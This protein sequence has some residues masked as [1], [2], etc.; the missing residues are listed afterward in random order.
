MKGEM[1]DRRR[2][3]CS[4]RSQERRRDDISGLTD[5][6]LELSRRNFIAM[7]GTIAA[8]GA[9]GSLLDPVSASASVRWPRGELGRQDA[10]RVRRSQ[11]MPVGRF[12]RWHEQ[13]ERVG[14]RNQRGLRAAGS[15]AELRYIDRLREQLERAGVK[16]LRYE[17]VPMRR[18]TTRRWSLEILAGTSPRQIRTAAYIPYSGKTPPDGVTAPMALV[19]PGAA[20]QPGSLRG[21]IAVFDVP[22]APVPLGLF[23]ALGYE[24]RTY[25]PRGALEPSKPYR[26]PFLSIEEIVPLLDELEA[27]G[28]V[29]AV[30]VI[31]YPYAGAKGSY[32]PYDGIIRDI[33]GVYV[34]RDVGATVKDLARSGARARLTLPADIKQ[35]RSRNLIGFIPGRSRELVA[36]HSH[37]DGSNAIEDN[38]PDAIVAMSQ[39]LARLPRRALP[40]TIMVLLT[41]GHF[42]GGNGARA[43]RRR[44]RD[45]LVRRTN[46]ALTIEHLGLLEWDEVPGGGMAPTGGWEPGAMFAPGSEALVDESFRAL[47]R[48]DAA[49]AGVIRPLDPD[50]SGL[51]N[52]P[53]WPGEGQYLFAGGGIPTANYITGP[54][55]LLNWGIATTDKVSFRRVRNEAIAFTEM[56]LRLTRTP[57]R[58]LHAYTLRAEQP[59]PA[60]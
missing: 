60:P 15:R 44:H 18:W 46:A 47:R 1:Y 17:P 19:E 32:F 12:R 20:P 43:F 48:A 52:D 13:L 45:G 34:D 51:P 9:I 5:E 27:A 24:G 38:G 42:A 36:L 23:L 56:I 30:G 7:G 25:D 28:A 29:G 4:A 33:P 10:F 54:T 57:R 8:A 55:Y 22:I 31:D 53:A 3:A 40:R 39:Y 6:E 11:F 21:K 35:V 2:L 49:P 59:A 14:P 37:T 16:G 41:T 50:A 26:R 58:D